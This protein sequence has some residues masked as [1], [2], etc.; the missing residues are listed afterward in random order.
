MQLSNNQVNSTIVFNSDTLQEYYF[1]GIY[2]IE[3]IRSSGESEIVK[4]GQSSFIY[5]RLANYLIPFKSDSERNNPKRVTKRRIQ[6]EMLKGKINGLTYRVSWVVENDVLNRKQKE[7]DL[8][9]QF[10]ELNG[11]R[12]PIMNAIL[13]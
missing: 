11:G 5:R 6:D 10:K 2:V 4:I 12:L 13:N 8:L 1:G 3:A 7:R 9:V